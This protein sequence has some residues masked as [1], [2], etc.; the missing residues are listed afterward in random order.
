M[1]E[2]RSERCDV[3]GARRPP[4]KEYI[5]TENVRKTDSSLEPLESIIVPL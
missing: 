4:A 3:A 2:E 1:T 5:R